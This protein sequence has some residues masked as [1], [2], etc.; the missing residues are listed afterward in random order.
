MKQ[1]TKAE[2]LSIA[3][4]FIKT[5]FTLNFISPTEKNIKQ[6]LLDC[7]CDYRPG[8]WAR[9]RLGLVT[10]QREQGYS[11]TA[12]AISKL[13]N[14]VTAVD[15]P[16]NLK[17]QKQNRQKRRKHVTKDEHV[18]LTDYIKNKSK[19][20]PCLLAAINLVRI[21]GCR[22]CEMFQLSFRGDNQVFIYG[23]KKIDNGLRGLDRTIVLSEQDYKTASKA[24][25]VL[26]HFCESTP[27]MANTLQKRLQ[28]RLATAT[29]HLWPKRRHQITLYSYRHQMGSDLKASGKS[30]EEVAAIMGHQSV[31]SVDV[32]G[33]R[34]R[35]SRKIKIAATKESIASVRKMVPKNAN[36]ISAKAAS[37]TNAHNNVPRSRLL[38]L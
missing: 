15:A 35:S 24:R 14:P 30:R 25:F 36:F 33:N 22:P 21:L 17:A 34:Q 32:Y 16:D 1:E 38:K 29:K 13:V 12:Q 19:K 37:K 10:Q 31:D 20:D 5:R 28:H 7:A 18:L 4:N 26:H 9:L 6:A 27:V 11:K 3:H 23:A 2:Y 8:Y